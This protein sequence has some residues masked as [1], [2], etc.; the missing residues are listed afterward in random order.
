MA[1]YSVRLTELRKERGISQKEAAIGLGVS[2]ALLSHY[3]KGIREFGLSFLAKAAEFY[4]VTSD[5]LI[6][7]SDSKYGLG[8][9]YSP[10]NA[11]GNDDS[12]LSEATIY[13]ASAY[14]REMAANNSGT[15]GENLNKFYAIAIYC[16]IISAAA[17]G[18]VPVTWLRNKNVIGDRIYMR[19]LENV[20]HEILDINPKTLNF[21][22]V[23]V[24]VCVTTLI[25]TAENL[26][27]SKMTDICHH[28]DVM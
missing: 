24:P 28:F 3:E 1:C 16:G 5:Y 20:M 19:L 14:L 13:R 4:C 18:N 9:I 26:L 6:G 21:S 27:K 25:N 23:D 15:F 12:V 2:Q 7:I 10:D 11:D 22:S 17:E 8:Q